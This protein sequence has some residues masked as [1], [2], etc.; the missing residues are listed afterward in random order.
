MLC[1]VD[2]QMVTDVLED[3]MP[4][5]SGSGTV[6]RWCNVHEVLDIDNQSVFMHCHFLDIPSNAE[7]QNA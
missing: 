1:Y 7:V 6:R 4:P 5:P 2:W 3:I